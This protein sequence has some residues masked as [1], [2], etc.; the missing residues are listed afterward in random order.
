MPMRHLKAQLRRFAAARAGATS[1]EYAVIAAG[2]AG[3][4]VAVVNTL[5]VSVSGMFT[6]A[7][8]MFH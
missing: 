3:V 4:L 2:I 8:N 7:A 5:G 6:A 1:I